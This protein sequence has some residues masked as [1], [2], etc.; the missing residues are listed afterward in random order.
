VEAFALKAALQRLAASATDF[1]NSKDIFDKK[2][3]LTYLFM[4]VQ[5]IVVIRGLNS[6]FLVSA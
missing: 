2:E 1:H 6:V 5:Q 3:W 4:I